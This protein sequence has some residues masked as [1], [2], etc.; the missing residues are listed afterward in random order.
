M[1][2]RLTR[3]VLPPG[4]EFSY[5]VFLRKRIVK[6]EKTGNHYRVYAIALSEEV[7]HNGS[8]SRQAVKYDNREKVVI[9]NLADAVV[10]CIW[11][12]HYGNNNRVLTV[13]LRQVDDIELSVAPLHGM[14]MLVII[15]LHPILFLSCTTVF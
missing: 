5:D 15:V 12:V 4:N 1:W 7:S 6:I 13:D 10:D 9:E 14:A 2:I 11:D 3:Y 8:T